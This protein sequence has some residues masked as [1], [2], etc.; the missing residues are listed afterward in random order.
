MKWEEAWV[1]EVGWFKSCTTSGNGE[2]RALGVILNGIQRGEWAGPVAQLR[3]IPA[4][5]SIYGTKKKRLPSFMLSASTRNGSRKASDLGYHTG[6]LQVDVDKVGADEAPIQRD[7]LMED[8]HILAAWVSPGGA[9]VKAAMCIPKNL[10]R[11]K[12]AF[13]AARAHIQKAFG[14]AIDGSCCEPNRLCFV[15]HD[16]D[17]KWKAEAVPLVVPEGVLPPTGGSFEKPGAT[18]QRISSEI[19]NSDTESCILRNTAK[20]FEEFPALWPLYDRHVRQKFGSIQPGH[21]NEAMV[22]LVAGTF[23]IICPRF[24]SEFAQHYFD[25]NPELFRDYKRDKYAREVQCML[26]GCLESYAKKSLSLREA[27][28]YTQLDGEWESAAFRICH[29]LSRCESNPNYPPPLF[30]LG[31]G[32][33]GLRVDKLPMYGWR[34]LDRLKKAGVIDEVEKG[35]FRQAGQKARATVWRWRL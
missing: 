22:E 28:A 13:A 11:H 5:A 30:F 29:G 9:G 33:L 25:T 10:A 7:R 3:R 26:R 2:N 4:D 32:E 35:C 15:S 31:G 14:V 1:T 18:H 34:F 19:L 21:R 12:E 8:P 16:P 24:V 23:C 6:L 27:A 20:F 17:L